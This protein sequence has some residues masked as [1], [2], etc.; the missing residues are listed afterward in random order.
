MTDQTMPAAGTRVSVRP[1][2]WLISPGQPGHTYHDI[3]VVSVHDSDDPAF[4]WLRGH[5]LECAWESSDCT[6]PW[7]WELLVDVDVLAEAADGATR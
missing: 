7:C 2:D 3:R 6:A 1:G 5:G 4:V